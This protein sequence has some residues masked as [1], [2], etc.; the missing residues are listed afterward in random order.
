MRFVQEVKTKSCPHEYLCPISHEIMEDPVLCS[1]GHT[2]ET[3]NIE[4]WLRNHNTSPLTNLALETNVL[5]PNDKLREEIR[6]LFHSSAPVT[7]EEPSF[8]IIENAEVQCICGY[9]DDSW[10]WQYADLSA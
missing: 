6:N 8:H 2:Y 3:A 4:E 10:I 5:I 1:D 7:A 9:Q